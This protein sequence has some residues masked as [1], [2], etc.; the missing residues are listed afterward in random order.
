MLLMN[1]IVKI[2][3]DGKP[4]FSLRYF[5]KSAREKTGNEGPMCVVY[6]AVSA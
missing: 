6:H 2:V 5:G 3:I 4:S 1:Y